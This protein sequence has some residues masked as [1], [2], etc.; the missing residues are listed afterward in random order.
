MLTDVCSISTWGLNAE[1]EAILKDIEEH[2]V[3]MGKRW[4]HDLSFDA[5]YQKED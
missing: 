1:V 3:Q 5:I 4:G 2:F